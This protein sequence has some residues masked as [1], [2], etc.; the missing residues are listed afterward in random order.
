MADQPVSAHVP[1]RAATPLLILANDEGRPMGLYETID[2]LVDKL[3]RYTSDRIATDPE[4]APIAPE[5]VLVQYTPT[6]RGYDLEVHLPREAH[7]WGWFRA[8]WYT[9]GADVWR[10]T[11]DDP[12]D[13]RK[14]LS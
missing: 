8:Q 4:R 5:R 9:C 11:D 6:W 2:E 3:Q 1:H 14:D 13:D 10:W 7:P 12:P